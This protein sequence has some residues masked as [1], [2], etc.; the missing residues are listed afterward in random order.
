MLYVYITHVISHIFL[1]K[2]LHNTKFITNN[3]LKIFIIRK[4]IYKL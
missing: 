2:L 4:I 3:I 1:Q